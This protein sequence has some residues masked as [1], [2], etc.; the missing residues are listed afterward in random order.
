ML[1]IQSLLIQKA[2]MGGIAVPYSV[3]LR[4]VLIL[5]PH[6]INVI[7]RDKSE[8]LSGISLKLCESKQSIFIL[9][10]FKISVGNSSSSFNE[11]SSDLPYIERSVIKPFFSYI[12]KL[13][14]NESNW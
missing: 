6:I 14:K 9:L 7:K 4:S 3:G 12:Y 5:V 13:L 1:Y 11:Y 10:N 2:I 8:I